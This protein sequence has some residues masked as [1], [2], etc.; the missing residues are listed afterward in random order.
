MDSVFDLLRPLNVCLGLSAYAA[1]R[2]LHALY[3]S[4]LRNVPGPF[5]CRVSALPMLYYDLRGQEPEFMQ[6][7]C[8]KYGSIFVMEPT[9]VGVCGQSEC[10]TVLSSHGFLKDKQY[11]RVKFIE[12]NMFLTRSPELNRLRRRQ[13]GG[14]LQPRSLRSMEP[15]VLGAGVC[16][17][18]SKWDTELALSGE[19]IRVQYLSEFSDMAFD[20]I[21]SLGFGL[22]H[23]SLTTK[24]QK[25][26]T[27]VRKT[28]QLMFVEIMI[29]IKSHAIQTNCV[30]GTTGKRK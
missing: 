3:I 16:Q 23:R 7:N 28:T 9:K 14:A 2:I 29:P 24:D 27:W 10:Q 13:I 20:V 26:A 30:E 1:Y 17:L 25:M 5:W 4:P 19:P 8:Q 18:M 22:E 6:C 15:V 21:C 11:A 12:P